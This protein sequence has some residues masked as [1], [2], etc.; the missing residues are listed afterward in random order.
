LLQEVLAADEL[1]HPLEPLI[2]H[3][4][5]NGPLGRLLVLLLLV[6]VLVMV[7]VMAMVMVIMMLI[8]M[9]TVTVVMIRGPLGRLFVLLLPRVRNSVTSG[10]IT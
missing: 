4:I 7:M 1:E 9:V 8:V 6:L 3:R 5:W 10:C 2:Q